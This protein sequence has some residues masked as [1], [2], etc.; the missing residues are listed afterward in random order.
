V[1]CAAAI[2]TLDVMADEHLLDNVATIEARI[3]AGASRLGLP[4]QGKG[5]LLGL[6]MNRPAGEIQRELFGRR[7]LTGTSSD[8]QVLRLLPPLNFSI[9]EADLLLHA[10]GESVK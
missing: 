4:V 6:G 9:D 1:P 2:A 5:L 10:L 3:R 7:V 8:P